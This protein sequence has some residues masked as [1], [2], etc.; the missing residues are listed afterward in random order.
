[1]DEETVLFVQSSL[2]SHVLGQLPVLHGA[3]VSPMKTESKQK[4][5]KLSITIRDR[6]EACV[7][8]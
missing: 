5:G 2:C 3:R 8:F 1:M 4:V 7:T 6:V